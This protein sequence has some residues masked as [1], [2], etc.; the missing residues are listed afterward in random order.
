VRPEIFGTLFQDSMDKKAR[1]AFG[2]HFTSEFDIRKVVGPT[3]VKPWRERIEAAGRMLV[4]YAKR[5]RTFAPFVFSI[6][7]AAPA[8]SYSSHI[9]R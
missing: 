9:G 3:I 5:S 7:P 4:N 1:H 8:T 2:A 6:P